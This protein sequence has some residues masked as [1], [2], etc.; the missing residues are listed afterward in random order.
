MLDVKLRYA[1]MVHLARRAS[2]GPGLHGATVTSFTQP[3]EIVW[4]GSSRLA[5][6][7]AEPFGLT[8]VVY[9]GSLHESRID[10]EHLAELS[11]RLP[12]VGIALVGPNDRLRS[13]HENMSLT[14]QHAAQATTSRNQS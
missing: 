14:S 3:T 7:P 4:P 5:P 9:V 2:A 12:H 11:S 6:A 10:V 13:D 1:W 8:V